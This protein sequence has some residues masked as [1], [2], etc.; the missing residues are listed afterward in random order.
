MYWSV[1]LFGTFL[2]NLPQ[3]QAEHLHFQTSSLAE[4]AQASCR[5]T[6]DGRRWPTL[7]GPATESVGGVEASLERLVSIYGINEWNFM[8]RVRRFH[9]NKRE[10]EPCLARNDSGARR[11][12]FAWRISLAVEQARCA[13][14]SWCTRHALCEEEPHDCCVVALGPVPLA[15]PESDKRQTKWKG[16][17]PTAPTSLP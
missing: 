13:G 15:S 10:E 3:D 16:R 12:S 6:R 4:C 9:V 17:V 5:V 8:R 7:T 1:S 11:W 14:V 2:S